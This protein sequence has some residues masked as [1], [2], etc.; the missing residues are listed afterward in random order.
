MG[1]KRC[2]VDLYPQ[3]LKDGVCVGIKLCWDKA[4]GVNEVMK[5]VGPRYFFGGDGSID[6]NL[7]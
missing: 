2:T 1:K 5:S 4:R 6:M 3:G 7:W